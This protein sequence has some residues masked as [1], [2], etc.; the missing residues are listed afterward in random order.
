[1]V[2]HL[3]IGYLTLSGISTVMFVCATII[4]SLSDE[5]SERLMTNPIA[6]T[7]NGEH[8]HSHQQ[9]FPIA[10]LYAQQS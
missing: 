7:V 5:I 2:T 1:M 4:G 8:L 9:D 10:A 3:I 6:D